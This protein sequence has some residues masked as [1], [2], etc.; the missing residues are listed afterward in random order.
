MS[1]D[2][3]INA[4]ARGVREQTPTTSGAA[5]PGTDVGRTYTVRVG[6]VSDRSGR[7][8]ATTVRNDVIPLEVDLDKRLT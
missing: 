5:L 3:R 2:K 1:R 6:T 4:Y 8:H 7:A